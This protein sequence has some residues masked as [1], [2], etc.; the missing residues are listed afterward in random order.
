MSHEIAT[1][2]FLTLPAA[3]WNKLEKMLLLAGR[4]CMGN[5]LSVFYAFVPTGLVTVTSTPLNAY[6]AL[7][8]LFDRPASEK[9][10]LLLPIG[11]PTEDATVP[12]LVRKPLDE[13]MILK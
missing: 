6:G 11:Y 8:S 10:F 9:A 3:C 2:Y 1:P 13:I 7:R 12:D 5:L 4:Y